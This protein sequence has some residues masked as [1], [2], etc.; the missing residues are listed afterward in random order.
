MATI[1]NET[2]EQVNNLTRKA[3]EGDYEPYKWLWDNECQTNWPIIELD[4]KL[5]GFPDGK[6]DGHPVGTFTFLR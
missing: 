3:L 1:S 5:Y 2:Y 6:D 4:G